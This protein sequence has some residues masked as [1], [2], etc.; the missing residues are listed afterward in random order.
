MSYNAELILLVD[1]SGSMEWQR[2]ATVAS[3]NE[4]VQDQKRQPGDLAITMVTFNSETRPR[5]TRVPAND[6]EYLTE[7]D[8]NPAG[9]TAL[10]DAI[11][12]TL[13]VVEGWTV[14]AGTDRIVVIVTDGASNMGVKSKDD[15][16]A[17]IDRLVGQGWKFHFV[18]SGWDAM[19]AGQGIG[20]QSLAAADLTNANG[21]QTAYRSISATVT[22]FRAQP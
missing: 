13:D 19:Q 18:G 20:V 17:R 6:F 12:D 2:A 7:A 15:A 11:C 14:P 3:V 4:L 16:K 21:T 5:R 9:G 10:Y 1:E 22:A 8:Y